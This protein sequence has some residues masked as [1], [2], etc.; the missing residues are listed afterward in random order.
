[1]HRRRRR[2]AFDR[3]ELDLERVL[4]EARDPAVPDGAKL[5]YITRT[6]SNEFWGYERDG[7]ENRAKDAWREED[8]S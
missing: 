5:C 7:F 4:G 6:L 3:I 1:M 8:D 2:Q